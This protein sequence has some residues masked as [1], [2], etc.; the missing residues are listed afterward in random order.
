[1]V[2]FTDWMSEFTESEREYYVSIAAKGFENLTPEEEAFLERWNSAKAV[3]DEELAEYQ[4]QM[5][6]DNAIA[7]AHSILQLNISLA[8]LNTLMLEAIEAYEH[9]IGGDNDDEQEQT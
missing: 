2:E 9:S 3:F 1:M 5:Q 6:A 7:H 8:Q 4:E